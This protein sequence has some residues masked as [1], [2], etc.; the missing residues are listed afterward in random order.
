M[1]ALWSRKLSNQIN[2]LGVSSAS[3]LAC[4]LRLGV[5]FVVVV[6]VVALVIDPPGNGH[7]LGGIIRDQIL[8]QPT[9]AFVDVGKCEPTVL[10]THH[11]HQL[12]SGISAGTEQQ[13]R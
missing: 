11:V 2:L 8:E 9:K 5:V 1:G 3:L 10:E 7:V 6:V 4:G 12:I 13:Q